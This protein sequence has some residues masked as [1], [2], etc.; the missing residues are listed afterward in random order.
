MKDNSKFSF[1]CDDIN[2][3]HNN[4]DEIINTISCYGIDFVF[5]VPGKLLYPLINSIDKSEINGIVCAHETGCGF[6]ADGYSR[7]SQKF[8]VCFAISGPGVMNLVPAMAAAQAD[9]VPVLYLSGSIATY[10]ESQGAFQDG[11]GNGLSELG[12]VKNIINSSSEIKNNT[13]LKYELRNSIRCLNNR[14]KGRSY[15]SIPIDIQKKEPYIPDGFREYNLSEINKSSVDVFA[16]DEVIESCFLGEKRIAILSGG[17]VNNK[18]SALLLKELAMKYNI[19]ISVTLSGK[20]AFP[21]GHPLFL[22]IYGFAGHMQ[23]IELINNHIDVLIVIGSHL[24]Q[25]DSL[26]WSPKLHKN[27]KIILIDDEL[28]GDMHY[29]PNVNILSS[30]DEAMKHI[31]DGVSDDDIKLKRLKYKRSEWIRSIKESICFSSYIKNDVLIENKSINPKDAIFTLRRL[32]PSDANV[33]VDSGAHRIFMAHYWES[34]GL[35]EY[36]TSS[37]LAPMGWAICAGIGIKIALPEREC[38]VVTGDGCML[39]HGIEIQ[40]AARYGIKVL[41]IVMNNSSHGAIYS[42]TLKGNGISEKYSALPSHDWVGFSQSLGVRSIRVSTVNELDN[43]V[44]MYKRMNSPF[45][46]DVVVSN[47][48]PPNKF[49]SDSATEFESTFSSKIL[50]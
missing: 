33:V 18:D 19:P 23:S 32:I 5:F 8:G 47:D 10:H 17:K 35:G 12:M 44:H 22:G 11:S 21:E 1:V 4:A 9:K 50:K 38:M 6:M 36:Y 25:R 37:S 46:I 48:T 14:I 29:Y 39:M 27:K 24:N 26:H 15:L 13:I 31:I 7:A 30:I 16:L 2:N 34:S 28:D 42:D 20:G 3:G 45:L 43:A 49:Y 41:F 40:T